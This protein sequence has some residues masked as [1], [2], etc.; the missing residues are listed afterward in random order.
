MKLPTFVKWAGGKTQLIGQYEKHF[1]KIVNTYYEPFV[2]SGA[3]FFYIMKKI[4]PKKAVISDINEELINTYIVVRDNVEELIESLKRHATKHSKNSEEYYYKIRKQNPRKLS[5]VE[6]ASR[7]IYLNKTCFNGLYRV[8]SKGEFN[9]PMGSYKNPKIV[10]EDNLRNASK[11]LQN[12]EIRLMPFEMVAEL[13]NKK[14]F[15]YFDPPYYPLSKTSSFTGYNKN[16]FLEKEQKKLAQV[17]EA[18]NNKGTFLMLSN[19]KTELIRKLY[20]QESFKK[21]DIR[22]RRAINCIGSKRGEVEELL[23]KNF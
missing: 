16:N 2:G 15:V 11:L 10:D 18:L 23:I 4:K 13:A 8:N 5:E 21:Y 20:A 3:V 17:F 14:D 7:F 1:P 22:A 6:R 19:S 12:V 9:V